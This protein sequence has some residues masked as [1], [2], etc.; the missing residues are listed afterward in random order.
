MYRTPNETGID[1]V[2]PSDMRRIYE[3]YQARGEALPIAVA[4]GTATP[5][6]LAAGHKAPPGMDEYALA[7]G[8]YGEP[9]RL[10][11]CATV[12]LE[13]PASAE[14]VLEGEITPIGWKED[15][16]P[17]GDFTGFKGSIRWNPLFKIKA[18][19]QRKQPIFQTLHL[20]DETHWLAAPGVE[21]MAWRA[22]REASVE[23]T[24]VYASP[25]ACCYWHIYAAI[26]KRPGEGK[27]ALLALMS[28]L[29][30]KL[31]IVTDDDVDLTD[32]QAVERALA[33]RVQ[34]DRDVIIVSGARGKHLDPTLRASQL[35]R[36]SL[37]TTSKM[38]ID[39]TVPEGVDRSEYETLEY[40]F[41]EEARLEDFL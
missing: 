27:N 41:M 14:I 13:V 6:L 9:L 10:T 21:A 12:D 16:G 37:P 24:A 15:E 1:L 33:F 31:A 25:A 2:S 29:D 5:E 35:P 38:G 19:M 40:P 30:V 32:P 28:L 36:G 23:T 17:Y 39:A 20:P 7:G 8:F 18:I 34:A 22:L 3:R 4:L 26:K 11:K